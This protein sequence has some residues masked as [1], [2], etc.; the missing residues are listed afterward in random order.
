MYRETQVVRKVEVN[1]NG[2]EIL[3]LVEKISR[4]GI[5]KKYGEI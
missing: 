3:E 2:E 1:E 5:F 4:K